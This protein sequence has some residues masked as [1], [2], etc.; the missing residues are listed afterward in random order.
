MSQADPGPFPPEPGGEDAAH[1][2]GDASRQNEGDAFPHYEGD[3]LP[4]YRG[5]AVPLRRGDAFPPYK[6]E[7]AP[8]TGSEAA[9]PRVDPVPWEARSFQGRRA[10]VVTR[11]A[12]NA[13]L[14]CIPLTCA[15]V[16]K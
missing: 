14:L 3:A 16:G 4:Q 7:V 8:P 12:A 5:A 13:R 6:R 11:T 9:L 15:M 1:F 10:G 2:R